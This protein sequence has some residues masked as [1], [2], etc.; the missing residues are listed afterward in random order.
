VLDVETPFTG[1]DSTRL[2][3]WVR[4]WLKRVKAALGRKPM[5]YTN[6]S[7]W[8][9]TGGTVE[10]ARATSTWTGCGSGSRS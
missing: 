3:I 10:F 8:G 7:S 4:A 1:L 9:A 5:I 2:Q 6:A